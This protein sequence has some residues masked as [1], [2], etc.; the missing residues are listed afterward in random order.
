MVLNR[1]CNVA[2]FLGLLLWMCLA[3]AAW[4]DDEDPILSHNHHKPTRIRVAPH[5]PLAPMEHPVGIRVPPPGTNLRGDTSRIPQDR[6]ASFFQKA[7]NGFWDVVDVVTTEHDGS[8]HKK[9][10]KNHEVDPPGCVRPAWHAYSFPTCNDIHEVDLRRILKVRTAH[11]KSVPHQRLGYVSAGLWRSVWAVFARNETEVSVLKVMKGEHEVD[12]RNVDRHR[13]DALVMERLTAAPN[14]VDMYGFCGNTVLTEFAPRTLDDVIY[15]PRDKPAHRD[16]GP[17]TRQ[18]TEGRL[19]L[20]VG[21]MKGLAA[22]HDI[23]G[24]PIVHAD[25]QAKQFLIAADGHV[26]INDFNRCRFM[27]H[28]QKDQTSC[29]FQIPT[30]PGKSRS[31]EEYS[32]ALLDEKLDVYSTANV[33][34]GIITGTKAWYQFSTSET[35]SYIKK[36]AIPVMDTALRQPNTVDHILVNLTEL[37]YE[38]N[39]NKRISAHQFLQELELTQRQFYPTA[40]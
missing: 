14:V 25:I 2:L 28:R 27:A 22:I 33:L 39:P 38:V 13:R 19:A 18:T 5:D 31:P 7:V 30:S 32:E 15:T 17:L 23:A 26:K 24:G 12:R 20:A 11:P 1:Q 40:P 29:L 8:S 9:K 37:A 16:D 36:G 6:Q 4:G 10:K 35:K 21:V 3:W 34:Y